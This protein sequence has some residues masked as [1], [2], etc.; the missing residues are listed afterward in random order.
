VAGLAAGEREGAGVRGQETS[1]GIEAGRRTD[2]RRRVGV[3]APEEKQGLR[4]EHDDGVQAAQ[5]V[6]PAD[7]D[8]RVSCDS[9]GETRNL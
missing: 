8:K 9:G 1:R 4:G 7:G 6:R 2:S 5:V 3:P